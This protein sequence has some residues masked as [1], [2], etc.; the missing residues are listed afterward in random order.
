[1]TGWQRGLVVRP[2]PLL[3]IMAVAIGGVRGARTLIMRSGVL[4]RWGVRDFGAV[5]AWFNLPVAIGIA[6]SP[7]LG[8]LLAGS[9]LASRT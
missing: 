7:M 6:L 1:M 9:V 3:A 8:S 4:D 5:M 2:V